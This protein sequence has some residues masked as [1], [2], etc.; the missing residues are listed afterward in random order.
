ML[1]R[2]IIWSFVMFALFAFLPFVLGCGSSFVDTA[3]AQDPSGGTSGL[4]QQCSLATLNGGYGVLEQGTF[5]AQFP[6]FPPPPWPAVNSVIAT[7]DGAGNFSGKFTASFGGV[8]APGTFTGVYTVTPD[9]KY[10]DQFTASPLGLVLHHTGTITGQGM[11]QE[12]HFM[13]T[14]PFLVAL[15]TA[16]KTPPGGC[17][18]ETLKGNYAVSGQG[19]AT[20]PKLPPLLP[21]AHVGTFYA[22]GNGNFSGE[23]TIT[24]A[25]T[26]APD[27]FTA[28]YT[29][30]S[31]CTMTAE[32]TTNLGVLHEV[33]A[34]TGVGPFQ[35][36][37]TII[38]ESGWVLAETGKRQ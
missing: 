36:T 38:A 12:I 18:Q 35:E 25:G 22:D 28:L 20:L 13:Y 11:F 27:K 10:S 21:G 6:S 30:R 1:R 37:H 29:V 3:Q 32:I 16:K 24:I 31:D 4:M 17:S 23:D 9:C 7:Y 33:G 19:L 15:G 14:D 34:V 2:K 8:I 5:L 26:V